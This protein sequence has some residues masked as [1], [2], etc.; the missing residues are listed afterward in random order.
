M[1]RFEVGG[2]VVSV[3]NDLGPG[4]VIYA[5]GNVC[6]EH[7]CVEHDEP[8]D[9]GHDGFEGVDGKD[10]HCWWYDDGLKRVEEPEH[11]PGSI[12]EIVAATTALRVPEIEKPNIDSVYRALEEVMAVG[13]VNS[14]SGARVTIGGEDVTESISGV[15]GLEEPKCDYRG[16]LAGCHSLYCPVHGITC[17]GCGLKLSRD[18]KW[19]SID[20]APACQDCYERHWTP[21][22]KPVTQD[23]TGQDIN[24]GLHA[25][26]RRPMGTR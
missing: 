24:A 15:V 17:K 5:A 1:E 11:R 13:R 21:R 26:L 19:V 22:A 4:K 6:V 14:V 23:T 10:G 18:H 20:G 3:N 2:R 12:G 8:F 9:G 7:V 16:A 25:W